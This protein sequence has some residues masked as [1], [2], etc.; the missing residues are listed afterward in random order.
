[1]PTI[2]RCVSCQAPIF[3]ALTHGKAKPM[4]V[5]AE[6]VEGGNLRLIKADTPPIV[7]A[8]MQLE[9][10]EVD[11][12]VRYQSHFAS[13]PDAAKWHGGRARH[14]DTPGPSYRKPRV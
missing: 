2:T 3:W 4:P 10:G 1:M 12:G 6:P 13:C 5:D 11:D 9:L 8:S 14:G 7:T